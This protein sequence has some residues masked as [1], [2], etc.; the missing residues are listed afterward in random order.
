MS[1]R[2][3]RR[4][5]PVVRRRLLALGREFSRAGAALSPL[6]LVPDEAVPEPPAVLEPPAVPEPVGVGPAARRGYRIGEPE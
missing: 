4:Y 5:W 1:N 6:L 2:I 3:A